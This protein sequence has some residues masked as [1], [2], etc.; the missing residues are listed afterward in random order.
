MPNVSL[1]SFDQKTSCARVVKMFQNLYGKK[2]IFFRK[3][4]TTFFFFFSPAQFEKRWGEWA[5]GGGPR[6]HG[7][8]GLL[9]FFYLYFF[10]R[11]AW[12]F[13]R[14]TDF[15]LMS[16]SSGRKQKKLEIFVKKDIGNL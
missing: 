16:F 12:L 11:D 13:L 1:S 6:L 9:L 4:R 7:G 2:E 3:S 10:S 14:N 5:R 8:S 15:W